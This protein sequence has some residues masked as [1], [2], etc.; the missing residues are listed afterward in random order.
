MKTVKK[1]QN[2]SKFSCLLIILF[3]QVSAAYAERIKDLSSVQGMRDNQLIGYGLV[4]G[5]DGSGDSVGQ[6]TFTAQSLK[7]CC[8][9]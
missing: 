6:V 3:L 9:N 8:R 2:L 1:Q 5:L 4:V 7:T